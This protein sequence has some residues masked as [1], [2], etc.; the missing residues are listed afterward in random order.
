MLASLIGFIQHIYNSFL[1]HLCSAAGVNEYNPQ[2]FYSKSIIELLENLL[3]ICWVNKVSFGCIN[4]SGVSLQF[5]HYT[6]LDVI[7]VVLTKA[8][9]EDYWRCVGLGILW[10]SQE[11]GEE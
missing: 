6:K 4:Y 9:T 10:G 2:Y 8:G 5:T 7:K 3:E 1:P 11:G